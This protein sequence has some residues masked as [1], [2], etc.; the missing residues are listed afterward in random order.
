VTVLQ[1]QL[2][3]GDMGIPVLVT[4]LFEDKDDLE[5]IRGALESMINAI[6]NCTS[7][8]N[9]HEAC[10]HHVHMSHQLAM[11]SHALHDCMPAQCTSAAYAHSAHQHVPSA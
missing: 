8:E 7:A 4:V 2:T 5:L 11:A 3:F 1:A 6:A 9:S 10:T